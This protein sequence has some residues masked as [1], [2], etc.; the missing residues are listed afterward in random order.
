MKLFLDS[1]RRN[2]HTPA[3]WKI[4]LNA[5]HFAPVG[6]RTSA[7]EEHRGRYKSNQQPGYD[8]ILPWRKAN[9]RGDFLENYERPE[10]GGEG[11]GTTS[12]AKLDLHF[13]VVCGG[14]RARTGFLITRRIKNRFGRSSSHVQS[15]FREMAAFCQPVDDDR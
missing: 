8:R 10:K 1:W 12:D 3:A 4:E 14:N 9:R 5:N 7:S 13:A 11:G 6:N 2:T 15:V